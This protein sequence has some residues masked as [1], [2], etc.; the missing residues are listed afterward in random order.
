MPAGAKIGCGNVEEDIKVLVEAGVDFIAMDGFSGGTAALIAIN[1]EQYRICHT[2]LC[3]TGVTTHRPD[4]VRQ[5][6]VEEGIRKLTNFINVSTEE[7]ANLARIVGK[8]NINDF[9]ISDLVSFKKNLA[10]ITGA[11]YLT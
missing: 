8:N 10:E 5:L 3:P 7:I 6:D 4:L 11:K 1:C 2:G 9:G